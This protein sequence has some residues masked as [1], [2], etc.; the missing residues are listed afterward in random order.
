MRYPPDAFHLMIAL[1]TVCHTRQLARAITLGRSVQQVTPDALFLIGL[2]DE[3]PAG[4]QPD[5][6]PFPVIRA[7]ELLA[8][9]ELSALS[10][11]YTPAEMA[12]ALKPLF[13]KAC[14]DRYPE[15]SAVVYADP[16]TLFLQPLTAIEDKLTKAVF[17]LTP[18][19]L[20]PPRDGKFPDEKHLQNIGL[21]NSDF[22]A[23][24]RSEE[25]TR[26]LTWWDSRVR[27]RAHINFC[28]G[29]CTDQIWL[30]HVPAFF[31]NVQIVQQPTWHAG[32]WN[33]HDRQ[34]QSSQ[35]NWQVGSDGPLF[36]VNMK[37]LTNPDDG[38]FP[39]QNRLSVNKRP[40]IQSILRDYNQRLAINLRPEFSQKPVYGQQPEPVLLRGWR[41]GAVDSL[42]KLTAF[43]DT[44]P[45]PVLR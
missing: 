24:R 11:G 1:L 35:G 9:A 2:A 37:G 3:Q 32:L 36:F 6:L 45:I 13:L 42:R 7:S 8:A 17:L 38:F 33:L 12:G 23:L 20:Q 21:Y 10:A 29:L 26:F 15:H 30:M 40:D 39:Y 14:Y 28:E 18:Y 16:N 5:S 4:I 43:I 19:L 22:L 34:L 31:D 41:K 44:V 27:T 25:A